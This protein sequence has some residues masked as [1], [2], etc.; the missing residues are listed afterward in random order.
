MSAAR[1][2]VITGATATGK[3]RLAVALARRFDGEVVSADSRQVY[4]GMDIGT[5]KDLSEYNTGGAPVAYHLIDVVE[6]D[7]DFHLFRYLELARAAV[8]EISARG[9]L[10]VVAGGTPLYLKAMLDGYD[11]EGGAPDPEFRREMALL[12]L[13]QLVEQLQNTAPEQLF[14]RTDLTQKRRVIRA[15]ELARSGRTVTPRPIIGDS[16][17]LAP[18]YPRKVIHERIAARLDA[19]LAD[20]LIEEARTLHARGMSLERMDWMG[21][22][23]RYAA[24]VL[25]GELTVPQMRD[26]LL[27]RIRQFCKRQE[28]W[29]RKLE[30]EGHVIYWIPG[31]DPEAA[32]ALVAKWLRG[33]SLPAPTPVVHTP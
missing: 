1:C 29:F 11:Q 18:F 14:L 25:A 23:Y 6:P 26:K 27:A 17:V 4:R 32:A 9:H 24:K 10:P 2:L 15:L 22:E 31:G 28:G 3:T 20:G 33:E 8:D 16:L 30:R 5:G 19:R 7:S 13:E 12:P 21:L